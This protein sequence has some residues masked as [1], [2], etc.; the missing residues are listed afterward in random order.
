MTS[1]NKN[2]K[3]KVSIKQE[4]ES[5]RIQLLE[6]ETETLKDDVKKFLSII[7]VQ[8]E[9]L[10]RQEKIL[11]EMRD[12]RNAKANNKVTTCWIILFVVVFLLMS[13]IWFGP[14]IISEDTTLHLN[15]KATPVKTPFI[16]AG[17]KVRFTMG[18]LAACIKGAFN[19][20]TID[21]SLS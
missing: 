11:N 8:T 5:S 21:L 15:V 7:T 3:K 1:S 6:G 16:T 19:G 2:T 12:E 10:A 17:V 13:A 18:D 9:Q 14:T 4:G 20:N